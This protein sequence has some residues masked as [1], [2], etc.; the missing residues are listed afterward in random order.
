MKNLSIITLL[1]LVVSYSKFTHTCNRR[2][3]RKALTCMQ[4]K[5]IKNIEEATNMICNN[6]REQRK[7]LFVSFVPFLIVSYSTANASTYCRGRSHEQKHIT[8]LMTMQHNEEIRQQVY[9]RRLKELTTATRN[10]VLYKPS[11]RL[12]SYSNLGL[13]L[14]CF[15]PQIQARLKE[16]KTGKPAEF[17][18]LENQCIQ[19]KNQAIQERKQRMF[20]FKQQRK[21]EQQQ[22]KQQQAILFQKN[23]KLP[24]S[25][26]RMQIAH[27]QRG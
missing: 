11:N 15:S 6:L 9:S 23:K 2:R 7:T 4:Q 10:L 3:I 24:K 17:H 20:Q 14:E 19:Q 16:V 18:Q 1:L 8:N 26:Q 27:R 22:S 21:Q 12:P 13:M 25:H 5:S